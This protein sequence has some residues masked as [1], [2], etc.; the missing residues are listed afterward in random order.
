M[1]AMKEARLVAS[2]VALVAG[3]AAVV[4]LG[5]PAG[6]AALAIAFGVGVAASAHAIVASARVRV[7]VYA[8][9]FVGFVAYR[10]GNLAAGDLSSSQAAI[11]VVQALMLGVALALA[12]DRAHGL[13]QLA[14]LFR[15]DRTGYA[16]VVDEASATRTVEAELARS[17]RSGAPLTLLLLE[18]P[19]RVGT[20]ELAAAQE[21]VERDALAQL[22]RVHARE[23]VCELVSEHVRRSDLV[24]CGEER[25]LVMSG[26]TGVAGTAALATRMVEAARQR[27]GI[28]LRCG[29]AEFPSDGNTYEELAAVASA[30]ADGSADAA[31]AVGGGERRDGHADAVAPFVRAPRRR[32]QRRSAGAKP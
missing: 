20:S 12:Y 23:R 30:V 31:A 16:P 14:A 7:V 32:R 19:D 22:G 9:V 26:D 21:R 6:L 18:L 3:G 2:G 25:F 13:V 11:L 4:A 29:L 1:T 5:G 28:T 10:L 27:L 24:V 15:G 8:V 17:R